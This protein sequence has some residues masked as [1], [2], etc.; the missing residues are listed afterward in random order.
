MSIQEMQQELTSLRTR[1]TRYRNQSLSADDDTPREI[2]ETEQRRISQYESEIN[3]MQEQLNRL[4]L[5]STQSQPR[6]NATPLVSSTLNKID[7]F[8][9]MSI[10]QGVSFFGFV[11]GQAY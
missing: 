11:G 5:V 9:F 3:T 8:S 2:D 10:D 6:D 7:I 4:Q 1:L